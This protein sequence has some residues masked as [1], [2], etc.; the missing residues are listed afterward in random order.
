MKEI[1]IIPC[2]M[3]LFNVEEHFKKNDTVIWK[4]SFSIHTGDVAYIYLS[5]P[6]SEIRYRCNVISEKVDEDTLQ[7]NAYA[8]PT[9]QSNNYFSKRLKY[10]ILELDKTYPVGYLQLQSLREHGMGQ[11]Q[12]QARADRRLR[13][14]LFAK[15]EEMNVKNEEREKDKIPSN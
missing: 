7:K 4:N 11:T 8:I 10:I 6:Y 5:A 2:N 15:E 1:W 13:A 9:K 3:K 14:Y 12:I